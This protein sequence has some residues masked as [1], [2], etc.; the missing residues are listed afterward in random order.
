MPV[1]ASCRATWRPTEPTPTTTA[2]QRAS[3]A[4]GTR[5]RCRM[6]RSA[7]T[8]S[9]ELMKASGKRMGG[10]LEIRVPGR[11]CAERRPAVGIIVPA[12][13]G[14]DL[15]EGVV[16]ALPPGDFRRERGPG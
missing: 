10:K 8:A 15:D 16:L 4:G 6:S 1:D 12:P 2:W 13:D 14:R 9:E 5:S 7:S 11:Q 3:R